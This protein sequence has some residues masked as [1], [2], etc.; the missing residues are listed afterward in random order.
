MV[1]ENT[2]NDVYEA[3]SA[4]PEYGA[5]YIKDWLGRLSP[6]TTNIFECTE[7]EIRHIPG[8]R[9]KLIAKYMPERL[10][11]EFTYNINEHNWSLRQDV[12][13]QFIIN[14]PLS[15]KAEA[16]LLLS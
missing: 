11:D 13:D 15:S 16:A 8:W 12:L 6:F 10:A 3:V 7:R 1:I 14:F 2:L 4:C 5:G 9:I